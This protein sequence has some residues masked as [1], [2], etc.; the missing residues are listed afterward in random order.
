MAVVFECVFV[1][2]EAGEGVRDDAQEDAAEHLPAHRPPQHHHLR[3]SSGLLPLAL[4]FALYT[5]Q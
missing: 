4:F 2:R 5:Y 3:H 1:G